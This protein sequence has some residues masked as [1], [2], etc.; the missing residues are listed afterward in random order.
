MFNAVSSLSHQLLT[1]VREQ[2]SLQIFGLARFC[3]LEN[4]HSTSK[5][6]RLG[7]R[8]A[9]AEEKTVQFHLKNDFSLFL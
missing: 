5:E 6:E 8:G 3:L 1:G 2:H 4:S 7:L 9:G